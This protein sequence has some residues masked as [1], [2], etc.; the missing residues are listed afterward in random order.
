MA[1]D[2]LMYYERELAFLRQ[3]GTEFA[4]KYPKIATRLLLE[5]NKSEDPHVER[6]IQAFAFLAARIHL[7]D[8]V[9]QLGVDERPLLG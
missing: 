7:A 9:E 1:D 3:I 6:L 2:L 4:G 5:S 8:F